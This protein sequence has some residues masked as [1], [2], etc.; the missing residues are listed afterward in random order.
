M[1]VLDSVGLNPLW[2]AIVLPVD[3]ILDM[4]RTVVN[5][6]SDATVAAIIAKSEKMMD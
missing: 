4:C 6:T 1:I 3:R 2:V 5:V